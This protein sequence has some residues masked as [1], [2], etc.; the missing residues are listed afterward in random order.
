M[1]C[2]LGDVELRLGN[3]EAARAAFEAALA[4]VLRV[5]AWVTECAEAGLGRVAR[6]TG[7]L[8]AGR[9][10]AERALA[11]GESVRARLISDGALRLLASRQS[12]YD[13]LIDVLMRQHEQ[14]PSGGHDGA[15]FEVSER[16]RA[17]SLLELLA[18]GQVDVRSGVD[19]TLLAEERALRRRAQR[20]RARGGRSAGGGPKGDA[21][22]RSPVIWRPSWH[23]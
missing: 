8:A 18:E 16:A 10:H 9:G 13:L 2:R 15:A 11:T 20:E 22:T 14:D 6:D 4:L 19:P 5:G 7:D 17:R 3:L 21:R 1:R 12:R 23:A